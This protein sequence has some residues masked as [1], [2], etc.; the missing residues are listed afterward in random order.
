MPYKDKSENDAY[1]KSYY[2]KNKKKFIDKADKWHK[3]N[4]RRSLYIKKAS[5][6]RKKY[7]G[8]LTADLVQMVYEDN[9]KKFGTLTCVICGLKIKFG[10][11][12]L[13][14]NVSLK[15]GGTNNYSN[16]GVAHHSCNS[17]KNYKTCEEMTKLPISNHHK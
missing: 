12:N 2:Q 14:H 16:L 6:A 17:S 5:F 9:I 10:D 8:D 13:E 4:R 11:D 15:R 7:G 1:M 3:E